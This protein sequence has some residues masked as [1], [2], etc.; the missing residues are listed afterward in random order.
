VAQTATAADDQREHEKHHP[1]GAEVAVRHRVAQLASQKRDDSERDEIPSDQ[2]KSGVGSQAVA[3]ETKL[4][5][6]V[7]PPPKIRFSPPH[8][9]WP[10]VRGFGPSARNSAP[11]TAEG[12]SQL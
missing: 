11:T 10:F 6:P 4:Q 7:D 8:W 1:R 3:A 5:I 12:L 9:E 2:L